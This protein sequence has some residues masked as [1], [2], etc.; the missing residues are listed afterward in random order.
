[1]RSF[2]NVF[3]DRSFLHFLYCYLTNK[4]FVFYCIVATSVCFL[5]YY[6]KNIL[7]NI[8]QKLIPARYLWTEALI[9]SSA[10][11]E[12]GSGPFM[13]ISTGELSIF[14]LNR[15]LRRVFKRFRQL[16]PLYGNI[17]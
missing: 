1:M 15:L 6:N 9:R 13:L 17:V 2:K 10:S 4:V 16:T 14:W 7:Q 5:L 12:N 3:V 11:S 8:L